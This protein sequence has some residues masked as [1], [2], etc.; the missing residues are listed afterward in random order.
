[1]VSAFLAAALALTRA[2]GLQMRASRTSLFVTLSGHAGAAI[3]VLLPEHVTV[4]KNGNV[5]HLYLAGPRGDAPQWRRRGNSLEYERDLPKS[6]HLLARAT[7]QDDGILVHYEIGNRSS[8]AYDMVTAVTD[9]RMRSIFHDERLERT[10]V[11]EP[12]GFHLL[13]A[14]PPELPARVLA[15]YTWPIPPQAVE[16]RDGIRYYNRPRRIDEPLIATLSADRKWIVASF[17]RAAGNVWSN[18]EL[19]CQHVDEQVPLPARAKV[20]L[21]VKM[22]IV[23]GSLADVQRMFVRQRNGLR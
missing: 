20:T 11:H 7:L 22:L 4:R 1:M 19:P 6:I 2:D 23:R 15:S 13:I 21:E 5:E 14:R 9:P 3:E 16:V 12:D 10:Y 18:P 17:S 8:V